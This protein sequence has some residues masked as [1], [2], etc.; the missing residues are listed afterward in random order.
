MLPK[1]LLRRHQRRDRLPPRHLHRRS[2]SMRAQDFLSHTAK[3]KTYAVRLRLRQKGYTQ[4][5]D[6]TVMA[7]NPEQARRIVRQQYGD[8]NVL[9]GQPRELAP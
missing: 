4:H 6:S 7:R 2:S 1:R 8:R 9:V 5:M 3:L